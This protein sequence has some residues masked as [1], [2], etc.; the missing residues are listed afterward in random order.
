MKVVTTF[1]KPSSVLSSVKCRL[2][3][4]SDL[5]FLVVA[6]LDRL[7][8]YSLQLEGIKLET[9]LEIWGRIIAIKA[10]SVEVSGFSICK[11]ISTE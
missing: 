7:D 1:H 3:S 10:V 4:G 11:Y 8:V 6:K 2:V 9:T 5:E